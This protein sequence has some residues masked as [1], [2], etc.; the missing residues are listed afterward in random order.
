MARLKQP[1]RTRR[2]ILEAAGRHFMARGYGKTGIAAIL[3]GSGLT[4]G[5]LFHHFAGKRSLGL[6]W[7]E[8]LLV[9]LVRA[10][11]VDSLSAVGSL[12]DLRSWVRAGGNSPVALGG[13]ATL[14][15][16]AAE[17]AETEPE[18]SVLL[19][20]ELAAWREAVAS[21]LARGV[22]DAWLNRSIRPAD[23]AALLTLALTGLAVTWKSAGDIPSLQSAAI[24]ALDA[25][26]ETLRAL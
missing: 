2:V 15:G 16:L 7:V 18:M 12:A 6:A 21:M 10:A 9:P 4:R 14:A 17:T 13:L 8:E 24:A 25:Y 19:S 20:R 5:A 1:Q 11:W 26:L 23:E 22:A 3:E